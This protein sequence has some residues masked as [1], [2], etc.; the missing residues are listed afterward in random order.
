MT[1]KQNNEGIHETTFVLPVSGKTVE[2]LDVEQVTARM[3]L[4]ARQM[5]DLTE[6]WAYIFSQIIKVNGEKITADDVLDL[7]AEDYFAIE[8]K[9]LEL[10]KHLIS[11]QKT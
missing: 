3:M 10:K 6:T 2:I 1:K 5:V 7:Q 4:K 9:Y 11:T 8:E